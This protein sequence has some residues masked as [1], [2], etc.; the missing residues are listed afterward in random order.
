MTEPTLPTVYFASSSRNKYND[1]KFLLGNFADLQWM[2]LTL[3]E[4]LTQNLDILVRRKLRDARQFLPYLPF[5]IEQTGLIIDS[6][7]PLP[8]T[9]TGMFMDALGNEGI[10]RMLQNFEGKDRLAT[11]VT[12]LGYRSAK[13]DVLVF[14]GLVRGKIAPEPR[15]DK[16]FGWDAIFIP[17]GQRQTLGEMTTKRKIDFSTRMLAATAFYKAVLEG[18]DAGDVAQ[19]RTI[20]LELLN[21]A[22]SVDEM[23]DL[24]FGLGFDPEEIPGKVKRE[25]ARELILFCNRRGQTAALLTACRTTRPQLAWPDVV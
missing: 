16:G 5:F 1:Y 15:G 4:P 12:Y 17:E 19:N 20:F 9:A 24:I 7:Q 3:D 21:Q 18:P 11:A 14:K 2:E 25:K 13:G 10:C 23:D 6:W 8:G 22:F